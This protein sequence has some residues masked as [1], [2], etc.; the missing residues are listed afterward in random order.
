MAFFDSSAATIF[1]NWLELFF[2]SQ[3]SKQ[4]HG[5]VSISGLPFFP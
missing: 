3:K 4:Q 1:E 2:D 5:F